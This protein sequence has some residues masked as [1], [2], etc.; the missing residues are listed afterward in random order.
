MEQRLHKIVARIGRTGG[1]SR[2]LAATM[3]RQPRLTNDI[4]LFS[5]DNVELEMP[6]PVG[7]RL[8]SLQFGAKTHDAAILITAA[9]WRSRRSLIKAHCGD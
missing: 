7:R 9:R 4:T 5:V 1:G 2:D 6:D 3:F 8:V